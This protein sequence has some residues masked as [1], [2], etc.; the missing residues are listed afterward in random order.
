ME[1]NELQHYGVLG[2]KWGTRKSTDRQQKYKTKYEASGMS[3]EEAETAAYKRVKT[4]KIIAVAAATTIVAASAYVAYKNRNNDID[5]MM[6]KNFDKVMKAGVESQNMSTNSNKGVSDA[7]RASKTKTDASVYEHIYNDKLRKSMSDV[8]VT[9][10]RVDRNI[11][12]NMDNIAGRH[13]QASDVIN[14]AMDNIHEDT[15]STRDT[16]KK[17]DEMLKNLDSMFD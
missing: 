7:F 6:K 4:E 12:N 2:M 13:E 11:K 9:K 10:D 16:A 3:K 1:N 14:K 17:I 15:E 8:E 5:K